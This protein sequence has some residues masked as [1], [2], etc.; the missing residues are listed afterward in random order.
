MQRSWDFIVADI[1]V[2][3]SPLWFALSIL[4]RSPE[5][6]GNGEFLF[7]TFKR[8][9]VNFKPTPDAFTVREQPPSWFGDYNEVH[10]HSAQRYLSPN[11][12]RND[13]LSSEP[14]PGS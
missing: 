11:E 9:Y 12:F 5:T 14:C 7:K 4:R 3:E 2:V 13:N 6:S 10:P 1:V 8:D